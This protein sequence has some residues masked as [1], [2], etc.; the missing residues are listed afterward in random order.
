MNKTKE[1]ILTALIFT[2]GF[3]VFTTLFE[4]WVYDRIAIEKNIIG[5]VIVS[6][7]I[8]LD[9]KYKFSDKIRRKLTFIK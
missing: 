4:F 6:I 3:T 2:I 5:G 7:M 9:K 8:L 1:N